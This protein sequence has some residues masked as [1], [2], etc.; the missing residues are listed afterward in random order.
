MS[1]GTHCVAD[2]VSD[3][4]GEDHAALPNTGSEHG[5]SQPAAEDREGNQDRELIDE[6]EETLGWIEGVSTTVE[7]DADPKKEDEVL[8]E[9]ERIQENQYI[10]DSQR[11]WGMMKG[12]LLRDS[13]AAG[14]I[15][16]G[17]EDGQRCGAENKLLVVDDAHG[18]RVQVAGAQAGVR[19]FV[20]EEALHRKLGRRYASVCRVERTGAE[21]REGPGDDRGCRL[22]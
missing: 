9:P 4:N 3:G 19:R 1:P 7:V 22:G 21:D 13:A 10:M 11:C 18:R 8:H 15:L 16:Q 12:G 14:R 17:G 2:M 20:V 6:L 5:R